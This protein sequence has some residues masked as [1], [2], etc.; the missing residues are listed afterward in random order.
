MRKW[1]TL[2]ASVAISMGLAGAATADELKVGDPMPAL[3]AADLHM[4]PGYTIDLK[5]LQ[6]YVVVVE[7]WATWCAPCRA[8][9]PHMNEMFDK[10]KDQGVVF[11][12]LSDEEPETVT[13]FLQKTKMEYFVGAKSSS[14]S[15]FGVD[16]IPHAFVFGADGKMKWDGHPMAGLED[17]IEQ[18]LRDTP[19]TRRL[20]GGP[21]A[22]ALIMTMTEELLKAG[23]TQESMNA[24]RRIDKESLAK[25]DGHSERYQNIQAQLTS[26]ASGSIDKAKASE[27]AG[28]LTDALFAYQQV[29]S[30]YAGLPIADEA[31]A[32]A[33]RLAESPEVAAAQRAEATEKLAGNALKRASELAVAGD[34]IA[35]YDKA[36]MI[37]TKYGSSKA[38]VEARSMVAKYEG[39]AEFMKKYKESK[40]G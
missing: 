15:E 14:G 8:S 29:A 11:V 38:A 30:S 26:I 7:F 17:Q 34:N 2:L 6:G 16:G 32:S 4:P 27:K 1:T 3:N 28:K 23:K 24:F 20:G 40:G 13:T 31:A 33:K 10:F 21:E 39:D 36:K 19:P 25:S 22:N 18:A 9:I 12:G 35:A 37:V 5:D